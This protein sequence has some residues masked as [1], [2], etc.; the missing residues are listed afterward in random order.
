MN[1]WRQRGISL[2]WVAVVVGL[3]SLAA[4]TALMSM[5]NERNY[6]AEAWSRLTKS[7]AEAPLP[8]PQAAGISASS[9]PAIRKCS[10]NGVVTY[11]NVECKGAASRKVEVHD[12]R[13]VEAPK[14]PPPPTQEKATNLQDKMIEKA[15]AQ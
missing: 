5:R 9:S 14:A 13:G 8:Q 6:F 11:S 3:F 1:L 12:T 7:A 2:V 15:V 10:V 4:M